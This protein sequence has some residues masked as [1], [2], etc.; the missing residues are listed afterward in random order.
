MSCGVEHLTLE[1]LL[2]LIFCWQMF[3]SALDTSSSENHF[4]LEAMA[5]GSWS[6][7][8]AQARLCWNESNKKQSFPDNFIC[9]NK[10]NQEYRAR[11]QRTSLSMLNSTWW[12]MFAVKVSEGFTAFLKIVFQSNKETPHLKFPIHQG[13]SWEK[14]QNKDFYNVLVNEHKKQTQKKKKKKTQRLVLCWSW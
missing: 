4:Y 10:E 12:N 14:K 6:P 7:G 13:T 9:L 3:K 2:F 8:I 5:L 1:E 11:T